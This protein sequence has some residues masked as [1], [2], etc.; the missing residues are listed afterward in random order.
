MSLPR[1]AKYKDSGVEWLG[2]VPAHWDVTP[3]RHLCLCLDGRRVP[4][5]ASE[6]ADR[7]GGIPYWGANSVVGYVNEALFDEDLVLLGEDGAPFFDKTKPVAFFSNGEIWPNNHVHVL[8]PNHGQDGRFLAYA[9][10]ATDY[11]QFIDGSTRDKLTQ[12]AMSSIPLPTPPAAECRAIAAFLDH[13]TAKIDALVAEQERLIEL[14][15]EKRQAV[16]SHA[17]TKG[18]KPDV[19]MKDSGV[20][21]LGEIPTHWE[22]SPLKYS[23]TRIEQGASPQCESYPAQEGEWGVLKVGCGNGEKFDPTEQ[24]ALPASVLPEVK[25]EIQIHDILMSRGNTQELV[26]SA[27][28][29][30]QSYP[31]LL[32]CDLLYR[33]RSRPER[34]LAQ[35]LVLSL[36]S[37]HGRFQIE[38]VATGTSSSMKKISQGDIREFVL[39]LPSLSEQA[40]IVVFVETQTG[41]FDALTAEAR[42]AID[43]L[44]ERRTA[45]IS[46]AVTGQ[47]DVRDAGR[48]AA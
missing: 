10:N 34:A 25:H 7:Q 48:S 22:L 5:N 3:L 9:L 39:L 4:L 40:A 43:L 41:R 30:A 28:L 14:L 42:R 20:E 2:Q 24:K 6:R 13:E 33:F 16:I 31:R 15:K 37:L 11:A 47:V 17:V 35:Y 45:L 38:R 19:P 1:Y 27:T 8:R 32:L 12:S 26:G 21:W 18:L 29:I 44:Q 23:I 36:R 46:A